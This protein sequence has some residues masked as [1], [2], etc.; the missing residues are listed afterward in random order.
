MGSCVGVCDW[1]L[2][3]GIS[4]NIMRN[5]DFRVGRVRLKPNFFPSLVSCLISRAWA[6]VGKCTSK[7][8]EGSLLLNSN[9]KTPYSCHRLNHIR[10]NRYHSKDRAIKKNGLRGCLEF[11]IAGESGPPRPSLFNE[12]TKCKHSTGE[13]L[14]QRLRRVSGSATRATYS[15]GD[16][17]VI[18][19]E[20]PCPERELL[21]TLDQHKFHL[22]RLFHK[23]AFSV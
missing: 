19:T 16:F 15:G 2:Q 4:Y 9:D 13:E 12:F 7:W 10:K 5:S 21:V 23:R 17:A 20:K 1:S 11:D 14:F 22:T 8:V 18:L 3:T 6:L